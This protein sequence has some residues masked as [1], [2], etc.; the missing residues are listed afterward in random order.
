MLIKTR[1]IVFRFVRYGDSSLIV[2]IFTEQAG[3]QSFMVKGVRK[4][5]KG[6]KI[7]LFQPL[8]MLDLVVSQKEHSNIQFIKEV[9]CNHVYRNIPGNPL[10]EAIGFF[11]TEVMNRSIR[12]QSHAEDLFVFLQK[13]LLLLDS[14]DVRLKDFHLFFMIGLCRYLGFGVQQPEEITSGKIIPSE[15]NT[16]LLELLSGREINL[17]YNQRQD[18]LNLISSFY[19]DHIENFGTLNSIEIL[20]EVLRQRTSG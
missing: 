8:T 13:Q 18:L 12:E 10:R 14:D 16:G 20:Q 7:A 11:I 1:G 19:R 9:R 5:S 4:S 6:S 15:L 2:T 17:N 3:L